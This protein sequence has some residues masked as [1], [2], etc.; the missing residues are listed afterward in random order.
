MEEEARLLIL[1]VMKEHNNST[2][3]DLLRVIIDGAQGCHLQGRDAEDFI[4][5]NCKGMYFA[6]HGTTEVT[7]IWC[8]ML[9]AA[10]P[11]WQER[12]RAE[13][14]EVCQGGATLDVNAL[15]Q[16]RIVSNSSIHPSDCIIGTA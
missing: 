8:L 15:R 11:E 12:A 10:H 6:G 16:L 1:D 13:A 4:M 3:N 14:A 2:D 5:G 7:M 9:L